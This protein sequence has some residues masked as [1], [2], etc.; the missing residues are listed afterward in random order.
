MLPLK[1]LN[2]KIIIE[3]VPPSLGVCAES[4]P[5]GPLVQKK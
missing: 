4:V 1:Q 3:G 5:Q 2:L